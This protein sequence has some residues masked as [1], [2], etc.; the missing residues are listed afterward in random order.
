MQYLTI[1]RIIAGGKGLART[2]AGQVLM[3]PFVLPGE[4]VCLQEFAQKSGYIEGGRVQVLSPSPHRVQPA[5][6]LY[7]ICGGCNLQHGSYPEQIRIKQAIVTE[8]LQR[9]R[10][11]SPPVQATLPSPIHWAYRHR[12]R[13][14][15]NAAGAL[16]FFQRKSKDF[17]AIR[18]CLLATEAINAAIESLSS[19][20]CLQ[21]WQGQEI[22]LHQSPQDGHL[23]LILHGHSK[24]HLALET[25]Q[26]CAA[27]CPQLDHIAHR[28]KKHFTSLVSSYQA[29]GLLRQDLPNTCTL[30]WSGACF[31]QVNPLQNVRLVAQVLALLQEDIDGKSL[32]DLYC[33][34]GNFSIPLALAGACVTGVE[35]VPE[36]IRW[37]KAN[38]QAAGVQAD[39]VLADVHDQV[40]Q[41][42][43]ARHC[44]EI[45]LLDPPRSGLGKTTALLPLLQSEK[46]LYISCDPATLARDLASLC[47]QG[48]RL[49]SVIPLDMFPQTSHIETLALL[50]NEKSFA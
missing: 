32:L 37:A 26:A 20:A 5:C 41:M 6:S 36:S 48:F 12:L 23:S 18:H 42:V 45:I 3:A 46:I 30:T 8:S 19:S 31:S 43:Q 9:A 1:N 49:H 35:G 17:V 25:A 4:R 40:Q 14:H 39:F 7:G 2:E 33:G 24:Q 21:A 22:E 44:V 47:G 10:L 15:I 16:G 34:M 38:A 50:E 29:A 11:A 28:S 27:T 13:L